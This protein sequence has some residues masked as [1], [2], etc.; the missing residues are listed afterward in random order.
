M[1]FLPSVVP[2]LKQAVLAQDFI[3]K[4]PKVVSFLEHP[5]GPFTIHF[6]APAFKWCISLANVA[7]MKKNPD[8]LSTPQQVAVTLTGVIWSRY[9]LVITPKN[10]NLFSVNLFMAGT[11]LTQLYRKAHWEYMGGRDEAAKAALKTE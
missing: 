4:N 3:A 2:R 10:W 6:W 5:A 1:S 7:D 9:S 11:G 8:L